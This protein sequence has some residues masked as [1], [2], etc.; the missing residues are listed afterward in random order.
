MNYGYFHLGLLLICVICGIHLQLI[1]EAGFIKVK[2]E[3]RSQQFINVLNGE[4]NKIN[5]NKQEFLKVSCLN[6]RKHEEGIAKPH[7]DSNN[8]GHF[9]KIVHN[10]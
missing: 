6:T 3:D 4:K 2:A 1:E 9:L 10:L 8:F 7:L 5:S